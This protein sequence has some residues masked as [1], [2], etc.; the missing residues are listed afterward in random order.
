MDIA[1]IFEALMLICFGAAWPLSI[2]KLYTTKQAGGKSRPFLVVIM[3]GYAC[4]ILYKI[5]G[6]FDAVIYL[7][8]LNLVMVAVDLAL[9][10]KYQQAEVRG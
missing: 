6:R 9:S 8:A 5:Y 10:W 3:T 4:G 7:Y 1:K 2:F